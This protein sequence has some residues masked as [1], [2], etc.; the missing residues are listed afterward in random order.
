MA[1]C[2]NPGSIGGSSRLL[3]FRKS[4]KEF[5]MTEEEWLACTDPTAML[6]FRLD[7]ASDQKL[8]LF[9]CACHHRVRDR[10]TDES[11]NTI[12]EVMERFAEGELRPDVSIRKRSHTQILGRQVKF[13]HVSRYKA[14]SI[15]H[16]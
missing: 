8:R 3:Y 16:R 10:I 15:R 13:G 6:R 14:N 11:V 12:I 7:N 4:S 9:S 2:F 5:A 1:R